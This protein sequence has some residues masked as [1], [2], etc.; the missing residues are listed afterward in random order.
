MSTY[1]YTTFRIE[2]GGWRTL[3][4]DIEAI[5]AATR[6]HGGSV[7]LLCAGL[8][9]FASDEGV[10]IR[11]WAG[12]EPI[13]DRS[14]ASNGMTSVL[15]EWSSEQLTATVRPIDPSPPHE[16]GVYAHRWFW[17]KPAHWDEFLR[18]SE[19][20]IWP[21]FESDGCEIIGLWRGDDEDSLHRTLLVTRYPSV[22]HWER[23][24]LQSSEAPPGADAALYRQAQD[25][26]RRRAAI[27]E[28]SIVRLTRII[29]PGSALG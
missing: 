19:H 24:R 4:G 2:R 11:H 25:A 20:G 23:T 7:F 26:G 28:R 14:A 3:A 16:A 22:A 18:L 6:D 9:G 27:T 29:L 8:I 13:E 1:E 15:R 21:Y 12:G 17:V 5:D 10:L